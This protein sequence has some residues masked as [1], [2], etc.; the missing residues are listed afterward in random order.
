MPREE[1][2]YYVLVMPMHPIHS[3]WLRAHTLVA[4]KKAAA[5]AEDQGRD[6]PTAAR[7]VAWCH[8]P[9]LPATIID[10]AVLVALDPAED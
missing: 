9:S 1:S 5:W 6:G 7:E 2:S 10:E 4:I 8:L 3:T